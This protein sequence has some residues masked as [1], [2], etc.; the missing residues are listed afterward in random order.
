M[1]F[2]I[3]SHRFTRTLEGKEEKQE[4]MHRKIGSQM[5]MWSH[6]FPL[7][8]ACALNL[9]L[10]L[11]T[12]LPLGPWGLNIPV[13]S[14][15]AYLLRSDPPANAI[16]SAPPQ[17]VRMWFSEELN[18]FTSHAVIVDTTNHEV[19]TGQGTVNSSNPMEMDVTPLLLHAGT[20]VVVWRS[21]SAE[22][23]HVTG[24]SFI[25]RIARPDGSVP[26]VPDVLPTGHFPGA[27]GSGLANTT[28][29][30]PTIV[31]TLTTWLALL[32]MVFWVGGV[33]WE[34][35]ILPPTLQSDPDVAETSRV[36]R[37]RFQSLAF[38]ALILVLLSDIGIVLGQA[39]EVAG[40]WSGMFSLPILRAVLFGSQFGTVWWVRQGVAFVA[41]LVLLLAHRYE[42]SE[43]DIQVAG[44]KQE[45]ALKI[46][47]NAI[48]PEMNIIPDWWGAVVET[49]RHIPA[50]PRRLIA[51]WHVRSW[52]GRLEV[53]LGVALIV[54]F[55]L[56][57]HAAA[58]PSSEL[59]YALSV[60][61]FHLVCTAAWVGGLCYLGV[62]FIPTL[63]S[64]SESQRNRVIALGL[65]EFSA[66]AIISVLMLAATGSL[67]T[68]IH[69][70][71][72]DQLVTTLYGRIL[73]IKICLFLVMIAISAYHSFFLRTRLVQALAGSN[74]SSVAA[75]TS[76]S[77]AGESAPHI[78]TA[79]DE[80]ANQQATSLQ[81][82][83]ASNIMQW[84]QREAII[85]GVILLCVAL[86]GAFAGTLAPPPPPA[87]A[88]TKTSSFSGPFP[89]TQSIQGYNVTLKV[90]PD[91]FGTNTF[92][93]TVAD[94]K[95]H[96]V[97]GAAVLAE[98]TML[99][100]DMGSDVLQLEADPSS[101]GTFSGQ[102]ELTMAGHWQVRLRILPPNQ[103]T[104]VVVVFLF[105]TRQ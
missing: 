92:T 91:T 9:G 19:D 20:Y 96:T 30:G 1:L 87:A 101:T 89:Q 42:R 21:Q 45:E 46:T 24:S 5:H 57:G 66:V 75:V 25:F 56:S 71:A 77:L 60:D 16:L 3:A 31:Q 40:A 13:A 10:L 85:G 48:H 18:P 86:L 99:D 6:G 35:W 73:T 58:V 47:K 90:A 36:A 82:T 52:M 62:V 103:K 55:A 26:P 53:L 12:M 7:L 61:L 105:A 65:P 37:R 28:L 49:F 88:T 2:L 79:T 94:N 22:D 34:T 23:G 54:A 83:F 41:F 102:G 98:T 38:F 69:L 68:T 11:L 39:A 70:T 14:A 72:L 93:V 64:L 29:D 100:M 17:I 4:G 27:A 59:A 84:V 8:C 33:F 104:F 81:N 15:H 95:G 78:A 63:F 74:V 97:Q 50:L 67:N 32:G 43:Q 44:E 76:P 80:Q 51:G